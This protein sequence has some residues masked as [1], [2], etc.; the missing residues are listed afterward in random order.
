MHDFSVLWLLA[1]TA[2]LIL[3]GKIGSHRTKDRCGYEFHRDTGKVYVRN[4]QG[5]ISLEYDFKNFIPFASTDHVTTGGYEVNTNLVSPKDGFSV[6]LCKSGG[7]VQGVLA[8]NYILNFMD[9][10]RP[11]PDIPEHEPT[12]HLDPVTKAYDE[13]TGRDPY[14]WR[15]KDV[16]EVREMQKQELEKAKAWVEER[17][18]LLR[19]KGFKNLKFLNSL[20]A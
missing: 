5:E 9:V 13:K 6:N 15:K 17:K 12:R 7:F 18:A 2:V 1:L 14:Y 20:L 11:L 8:W 4:V 3:V 19:K 10:T 16:K